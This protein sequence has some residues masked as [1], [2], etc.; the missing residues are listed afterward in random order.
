[1][2][3]RNRNRERLR[4]GALTSPPA[5]SAMGTPPSE[6][7]PPKAVVQIHTAAEAAELADRLLSAGRGWPVAVVTIATG[8]QAP[9]IDAAEL[10]TEVGDL[11]EVVVMPTSNVSW[12]FSTAMPSQTQVYGGAG[13][14]YGVDQAWVS[15]PYASP[16]R[17]AYS[18]ADSPKVVAQLLSDTMAAALRAGLLVGDDPHSTTE[19][20]GVVQ[21]LIGERAIV[22]LDHGGQ[23]TI[24]AE[25]TVPG[26]ALEQLVRAGQPITGPLDPE[27]RRLDI[28]HAIAPA[29]EFLRGYA[30][31][32]VVLVDVASADEGSVTVRPHPSMVVRIP[33]FLVTDNPLDL[34]NELF[35]AGEVILA[36]VIAVGSRLELRL[37]DIDDDAHVDTPALLPGG[38]PWLTLPAPRVAAP[39]EPEPVEEPRADVPP[40]PT[41]TI[42]G[43]PAT[44]H[45]G[46]LGTFHELLSLR[47]LT[48]R[49]EEELTR[50]RT[51]LAGAMTKYRK[52][53]D[54]R[55]T[56]QKK[57][58][59]RP[60]AAE[61]HDYSG[62]FNDPEEQF[63]F[64]VALAWARRI[65]AD[66]KPEL[67][68]GP[69]IVGPRFVASLAAT[70]G[71]SRAKV[72]DVVVEVLTGLAK[73][74]ATRAPHLLRINGTGGSPA[75]QREDGAVCWRVALQQSSPSA[76]RLHYW[77]LGETIELSRI[78]THDDMEP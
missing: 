13:R 45:D 26:I 16:L 36:R 44:M 53:E 73:T 63:R 17:F 21:G 70:E 57:L 65:P 20:S 38:P 59:S 75:R 9:F 22:Q 54:T 76:R 49:Q 29:E 56:L 37:D 67:P 23:A 62:A 58:K 47:V 72:V 66:Q 27:S 12:A 30:P 46:A 60:A 33:R 4:A 39:I 28:R 2:P 5:V 10:K 34:V 48:R 14:V 78:V 50:T 43:P 61:T 55:R 40:P 25:L 32:D 24:W 15:D 31:G 1:M 64:E 68:L 3:Q 7:A 6:T 41:A 42:A 69:Y 74:S 35:T 18:P 19:H 71:I 52:A 51:K 8:S 11:G 77:A